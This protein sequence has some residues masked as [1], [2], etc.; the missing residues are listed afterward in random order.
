MVWL[1]DERGCGSG[2]GGWGSFQCGWLVGRYPQRWE[3]KTGLADM[4]R[5][6]MDTGRIEAFDSDLEA[7]EPGS[8]DAP[9]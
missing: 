1:G 4:M 5:Y 7:F 3:R 6:V 2:H 9:F 8:N